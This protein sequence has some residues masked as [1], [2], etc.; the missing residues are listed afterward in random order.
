MKTIY[1]LAAA[2]VLLAFAPSTCLAVWDVLT[3]T[4]EV[5]K[6]LGMAVRSKAGGKNQ[7]SVELEFPL[8]GDLGRVNEVI[9][10]VGQGDSSSVTAHLKEDRSKPGRVGVSFWVNRALVETTSLSV[11]VPGSPGTVGGAMYDLRV[12][13]FVDLKKAK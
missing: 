11:M 6:E 5:A 8:A 3:V 4:P 1:T 2:A 13:D 10:K 12:K 7:V 9:L